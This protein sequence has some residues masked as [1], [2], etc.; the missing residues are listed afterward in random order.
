MNI[1]IFCLSLLFSFHLEAQELPPIPYICGRMIFENCSATYFGKDKNTIIPNKVQYG[2]TIFVKTEFLQEFFNT[3]H[4][5][6]ANPY[7]LVTHNSDSSVPGK[8]AKMLDDPK[9]LSWHGQNVEGKSIR[10]FFQ[11]LSAFVRI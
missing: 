10:N 1:L 4:P 7:V 9:I 5:Q 8:F 3:I 6:I 11:Y 2:D